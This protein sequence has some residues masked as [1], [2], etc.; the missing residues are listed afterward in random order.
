MPIVLSSKFKLCRW[1]DPRLL[2]LAVLALC[3]CNGGGATA[4]DSAAPADIAVAPI[5]DF[6]V[7]ALP[8]LAL[9][10]PTYSNFAQMFFLTYCVRCHNAGTVDMGTSGRDYNQYSQIH[11]DA[12]IIACGVYPGPAPLAGCMGFPPPRQFPIADPRPTDDERNRL[13]LWIQDG[14]PM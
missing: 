13:V 12:A 1:A 10:A 6:S 3:A 4:I 14:L 2:S 8:D 9:P 7:S 5:A 11:R